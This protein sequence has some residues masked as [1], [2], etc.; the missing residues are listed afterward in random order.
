MRT[1][2]YWSNREI[3]ALY[4]QQVKTAENQ[5]AKEYIRCL[6]ETKAQ[7]ISLYD[8]IL[9]ATADGTLLVS[10]LY[11]FN[12]YYDLINNLTK[13]LTRLGNKEIDCLDKRL[14]DMY[15]ANSAVICN[16]LGFMTTIN[17]KAVMNAINSIWCG[18]GKHYSNRIWSN[19][20]DLEERVKKGLIDCVARGA[21]RDDLIKQLMKDFDVGFHQASR[22][23][24][25]ELTYVQT[26][27]TIDRYTDAGVQKV[28]F[29]AEIDD[30]TS[31]IC[32]SMDGTQMLLQNVVIG[33]N[34][35]PLH[36]FCRSCLIPVI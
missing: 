17:E 22:L 5:L 16:K 12:R 28:E 1:S 25:T 36:P 7:L 30:R 3:D 11:K 33:V 26:R 34:A 15:N 14:I 27:S 20:A 32:K 31:D 8:E 19:K 35:P 24:K 2:K 21:S 4:N 9:D 23:A 10:D 13:S 18:D 6:N 29:L